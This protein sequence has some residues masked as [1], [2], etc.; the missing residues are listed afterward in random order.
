M[1]NFGLNQV[2]IVIS[3]LKVY[4]DDG[5]ITIPYNI[6]VC[7]FVSFRYISNQNTPWKDRL[8]Y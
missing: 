6:I 1:P 2:M 4:S 8:E 3:N 5:I 7:E